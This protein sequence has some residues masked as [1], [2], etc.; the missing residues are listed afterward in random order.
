MAIRQRDPLSLLNGE[1]LDPL[2]NDFGLNGA[3]FMAIG[4]LS[5]SH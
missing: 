1:S 3:V 5:I 2:G 4:A